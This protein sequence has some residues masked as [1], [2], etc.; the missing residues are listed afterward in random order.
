MVL[1]SFD[2]GVTWDERSRHKNGELVWEYYSGL[3]DG[4]SWG[5]RGYLYGGL[6]DTVCVAAEKVLPGNRYVIRH[7]INAIFGWAGAVFCGLFA[8]RVFGAWSGVLAVVLLAGSPRYFADSMNNPKDLPFAATTV[9]A[10]Y[11]MSRLSSR[12]PYVTLRSGVMLAIALALALNIRAAALVY[13][14]YA[15]IL[16]AGF[17]VAERQLD[18]RRLAGTAGSLAALAAGVLLLGTVFWPWAQQA[19]LTRPVQALLGNASFDWAGV[20]L[21]EGRNLVPERLPWYYVPWWFL[22]STPPVV[23]I[24]LG[25]SVCFPGGRPGILRK[26]ALWAM[27][28]LPVAA[29]ILMGSTLYDGIRHFSFVYPI[30]IVLAAS[31]WLASIREARRTWVRRSAAAALAAG[32]LAVVTFDIRFHPNQGVYF[33]AL[34]GGPRGAYARYDMDYWGNS[35]LQAVKW[36]RDLARSLGVAVTI[37][38]NPDHLV[39]LDAE[40]FPELSFTPRGQGRPYL[41]VRLARGPVEGLMELAEQPALH[42]VRTPD[43]ALLCS[44]I[45]GPAYEE[46]A[47]VRSRAESRATPHTKAGR[48]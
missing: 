43:G 9:M 42:Q 2:F 34:V 4:S 45:P 36:S 27:A 40:R 19:P 22:I 48:Q 13:L 3:R 39:L 5:Q 29:A 1:A 12:W 30:L 47:E 10:L 21:F 23:L 28:V 38:G 41:W 35:V 14:G 11:Y 6:F 17:V 44:V 32:V 15:G 8:A 31:G 26:A 16:V 46:L 37:S 33:N 25:L 24:G 7:V 18:W 20:V